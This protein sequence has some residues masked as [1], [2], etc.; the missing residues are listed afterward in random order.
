MPIAV[1]PD[2]VT[3]TPALGICPSPLAPL[4]SMNKIPS[5]ILKKI[6]KKYVLSLFIDYELFILLFHFS[7]FK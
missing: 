6:K 4:A 3:T 7:L 5:Q 2:L 1:V